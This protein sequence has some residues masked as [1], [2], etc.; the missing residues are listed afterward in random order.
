[1]TGAAWHVLVYS[2][3]AGSGN[4]LGP[5]RRQALVDA[6]LL[7]TAAG[8]GGFILVPTVA[9]HSRAGLIAD[10][11][12]GVA[13][14]VSLVWRRSFP[15][16]VAGVTI[17]ASAVSASAA[18][19]SMVALLTAAIRARPAT[20]AALTAAQLAATLCFPLVYPQ[21]AGYSY[22]TQITM[23]GLLN[24]A[25]VGWGL[26]IRAQRGHLR[27]VLAGQALLAATVRDQERRRIA[28]EMHDML[29]HRLSLL[30]V[31]AG[32]LEFRTDLSPEKTREMAAVIRRAGHDALGDLHRVIGILRDGST[33]DDGALEPEATLDDLSTLVDEA[34]RTGTQVHFD[35]RLDP[36]PAMSPSAAV[37]TYRIVQEGLTNARKHA[38]GAPVH[39]L[40]ESPEA[41]G[42]VVR[43]RTKSTAGGDIPGTGTGLIGLRERVSLLGGSFSSGRDGDEF[44]ITARLPWQA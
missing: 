12:L 25:V 9:L 23:G 11:A 8:F 16:A 32:A 2:T 18:G 35:L 14:C 13:A 27:A 6:V 3:V 44:T 40:V 7:L 17:A 28:R 19:A 10:L 15:V 39:I 21:T 24:L 1:M 41:G 4:R 42:I 31:H 36:D 38:P 26:M 33:G 30:S 34:R 20:V 37:T 43:V 22:R 5:I 29:A